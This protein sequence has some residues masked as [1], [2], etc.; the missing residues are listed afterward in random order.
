MESSGCPTSAP[1]RCCASMPPATFEPWQPGWDRATDLSNPIAVAIRGSTIYITNAAYLT[2]HDP[3]LMIL[4]V[5]RTA[6]RGVV[7]IPVWSAEVCV[8]GP[9]VVD[10]E[11]VTG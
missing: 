10:R 3:S 6:R 2:R 11:S 4:T 1:A 5:R 8:V 7:T 9:W